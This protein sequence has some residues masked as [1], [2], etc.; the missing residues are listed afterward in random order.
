MHVSLRA[1][2]ATSSPRK[3]NGETLPRALK[4]STCA[5]K[6]PR[7]HSPQTIGD[8]A[9]EACPK[10]AR[11]DRVAQL[12]AIKSSRAY[13]EF[14][15][16]GTIL[17]ANI[18]FAKMFGYCLEEIEGR[19]YGI[20]FENIELMN[21]VF[22]ALGSILRRAEHHEGQYRW[23]DKSGND[24]WIRANFYPI[25]GAAGKPYKIIQFVT[26]ITFE[27]RAAAD[28]EGQIAA[29][30][31]SKAIVEFTLDGRIIAANKN[32]LKTF[33]YTLEEIIYGHHSLFVDP[34]DRDTTEYK[35]FWERLAKGEYQV[36]QYRRLGKNG[37]EVWIYA[38]YSPILDAK[39][40]PWKVV[41]Y[42]TD[43]TAQKLAEI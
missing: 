16:D 5:A 22:G 33:G 12:R 31:R 19:H 11:C 1:H 21:A 38:S 14:T 27:K 8:A 29:I 37:Q 35:L 36:G 9:S 15:L 18:A 32:F 7:L 40:A 34:A 4:K 41:K 43:I 3:G 13:V 24:V 39:G 2:K 26:D 25:G 6:T 20:F 10:Q 30:N 23:I 17:G 42:A 28:I